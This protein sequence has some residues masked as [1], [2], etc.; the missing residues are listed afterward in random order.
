MWT[1]CAQPD[2]SMSSLSQ[3]TGSSPYVLVHMVG[4]LAATMLICRTAEGVLKG[5]KSFHEFCCTVPGNVASVVLLLLLSVFFFLYPLLGRAR[6]RGKCWA[7]IRLSHRPEPSGRGEYV[8][9]I[10]SAKWPLRSGLLNN[11]VAVF[12]GEVVIVLNFCNLEFWS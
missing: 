2:G 5:G 11:V 10:R 1:V 9:S 12:R 8:L 3:S 6:F 7:A 4:P